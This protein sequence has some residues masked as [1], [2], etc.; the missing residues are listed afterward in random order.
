MRQ[1]PTT[2]ESAKTPRRERER[3]R[4]RPQRES[5]QP[6]PK[7]QSVR[8]VLKTLVPCQEQV[9]WS[10]ST[11]QD[12]FPSA[13]SRGNLHLQRHIPNPGNQPWRRSE[14]RVLA[15]HGP[16]RLSQ[17]PHLEREKS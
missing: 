2:D 11:H 10:S 9:I 1:K 6:I 15:R 3:E 13:L 7:T 4:F 5:T 16:Y 17:P 12:L 14:A 8:D